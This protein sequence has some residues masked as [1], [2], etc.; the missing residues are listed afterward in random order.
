MSRRTAALGLVAILAA[1]A[2]AASAQ[3]APVSAA[4]LQ[5]TFELA[6]RIT[7]A[8]NVLGERRGQT[9]DRTWTFTPQCAA[10]PCSSVMLSRPRAGGT[11]TLILTE[12][13]P[14]QY[15]GSARFYAP[16]RCS[17]RLYPQGQTVPFTVTVTITTA[18]I[19]SGG[20]VV[21][22]RINATYTNR[23]RS[24]LTPCVE[25]P[26]HDAATYHG[27]ITSSG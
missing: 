3:T 27:H 19:D 22:G 4:R 26:S 2:P 8:V 10:G 11:D 24:N 9:F 21:V 23:G 7:T 15:A 13:S 12:R 17:G 25:P 14:G 5:G 1:A 18:I 6:G 20:A 16:L